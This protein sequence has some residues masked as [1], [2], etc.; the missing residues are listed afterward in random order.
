MASI[1]RRDQTKEK[2]SL[3]RVS[4]LVNKFK[5]STIHNETVRAAV[6]D[7]LKSSSQTKDVFFR[8]KAQGPG[9]MRVMLTLLR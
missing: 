5:N 6:E 7:T 2:E 1:D 3:E 8:S 4:E 9:Y